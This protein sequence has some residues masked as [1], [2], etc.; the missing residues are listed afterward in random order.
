MPDL[1]IPLQSARRALIIGGSLGGLFAGNLLRRIGW[2]VGIF[3]RSVHD[4]DRRGGGIV[5]QP[6]VVT[7]IRR[8]SVRWCRSRGRLSSRP[9]AIS[10]WRGWWIDAFFYPAMPPPFP[11]HTRPPAHQRRRATR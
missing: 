10:P 1:N 5:L 6:E 9:F 8:H 7:V 11:V 2:N 3:E 4:L